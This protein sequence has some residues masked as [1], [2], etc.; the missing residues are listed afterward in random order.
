MEADMRSD[1]TKRVLHY[2]WRVLVVALV[3]AMILLML[4]RISQARALPL[5]GQLFS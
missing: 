1:K 2:L 4:W 5:C 3:N